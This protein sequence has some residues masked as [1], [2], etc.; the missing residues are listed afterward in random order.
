MHPSDPATV[1]VTICVRRLPNAPL[2]SSDSAGNNVFKNGLQLIILN[3]ECAG[4]N[5]N[6]FKHGMFMNINAFQIVNI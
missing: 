6:Y 1:H 3:T 5:I 2:G 4:N